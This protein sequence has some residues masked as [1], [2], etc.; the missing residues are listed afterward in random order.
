MWPLHECEPSRRKLSSASLSWDSRI[1][2]HLGH[3]DVRAAMKI[4]KS[5]IDPRPRKRGFRVFRWWLI[6]RPESPERRNTRRVAIAIG[7][8]YFAVALG[9]GL[10]PLG[11]PG[12]SD[13]WKQ[14]IDN[15]ASVTEYYLTAPKGTSSSPSPSHDVVT[16]LFCQRC[17]HITP[18]LGKWLSHLGPLVPGIT[19]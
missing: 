18:G 3:Y 14:S 1:R 8:T 6:S 19:V 17:V 5:G 10:G 7:F 4:G 9:S 13:A 15:G 2:A 11:L 12:R 16:M